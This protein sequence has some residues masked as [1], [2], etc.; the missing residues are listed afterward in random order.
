MAWRSIT[1]ADLLTKISGAELSS[2][3]TAVLASGQADPVP[4]AIGQVVDEC[5]GYIAACT[6]NT[7]GEG[8][9]VPEKLI[10]SCVAKI[11]IEIMT[12]VA[13]TVIDPEGAR[14]RSATAATRLFERVASC[15]FAVEAPETATSE[16]L[17]S[18]SPSIK[19]RRRHFTRA[20]Q[21]G[22]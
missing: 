13:G 10:G 15:G 22:I 19:A 21:E 2:L 1:E 8:A 4:A 9:T 6:N 20:D 3:R 7:L 16:K 14:A 11:I 17:P 12:R 5:R 18:P